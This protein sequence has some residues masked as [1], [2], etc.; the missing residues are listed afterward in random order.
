MIKTYIFVK[1]RAYFGVKFSYF[2]NRYLDIPPRQ[3]YRIPMKPPKKNRISKY[4]KGITSTAE[5]RKL[6]ATKNAEKI[7]TI[8]CIH[9]LLST[10]F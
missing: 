7:T 2:F 1:T 9:Q 3:E 4:L 10:Y 8:D 5:K 6:P